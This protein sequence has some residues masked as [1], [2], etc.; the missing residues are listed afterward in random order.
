MDVAVPH[1]GAEEEE[2]PEGAAEG[3]ATAAAENTATVH[4]RVHGG[5]GFKGG[6]GGR[7]E[8]GPGPRIVS[9]R[10]PSLRRGTSSHQL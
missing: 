10:A 5:E 2:N 3:G 9:G 1:L 7:T 4:Q 6:A 8:S